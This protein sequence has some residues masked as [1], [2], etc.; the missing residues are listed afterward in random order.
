MR[1]EDSTL[2]PAQK[3]PD[4]LTYPATPPR[5]GAGWTVLVS[6]HIIPVRIDVIIVIEHD[7]RHPFQDQGMGLLEDFLSFSTSRV[8]EAWFMSSFIRGY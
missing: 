6:L 5:S 7:D 4:P 3:P 2:D 1:K 8:L